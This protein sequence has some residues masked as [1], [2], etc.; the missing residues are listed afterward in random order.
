[1]LGAHPLFRPGRVVPRYK[2][3]CFAWFRQGFVAFGRRLP[4]GHSC[5]EPLKMHE[6]FKCTSWSTPVGKM[7]K[8][9]DELWQTAELTRRQLVATGATVGIVSGFAASV[10]PVMAQTMIMTDPAG[11]EAGMIEIATSAG[12]IPAYRA[13]QAG[14][15]SRPL[16]L[17]VQEIF[18]V[19]EHIKDVCRRLAKL[20]YA[21]IAPSLYH[22]QGDVTKLTSFDEIRPIV[23]TVPD[24]QVMSDLDATVAWAVQEGIADA[25]R[26]GITGYCWGGRIVWLYAAHNP[27]LKAGVAWYGRV[28]GDR[29]EKQPAH[30][31]DVAPK[32]KAPVLGLYGGA[33]AGIPVATTEQ[34]T[35]ALGTGSKSIFHI[36]PDAPHAFF[37]DYRPSYREAAAVDAWQRMFVWFKQNGVV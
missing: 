33:D 14:Q 13:V 28:V 24:A 6:F 5:R 34:M 4:A 7:E 25:S 17:V 11:L 36:Y 32:I 19:H 1:M 18:G 37:A 10:Q 21:A 15:K 3:C 22:R 29:S 8:P 31:V 35:A 30:P 26:L 27:N 20:G 23:A 12:P 16:V 2:V 9:F